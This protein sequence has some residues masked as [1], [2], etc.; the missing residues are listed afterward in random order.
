MKN[1]RIGIIGNA[2]D[3][4]VELLKRRVEDLGARATVIDFSQFPHVTKASIEGETVTYDD[5]ELTSLDAFYLRQMGYFSPIPQKE[6]TKEEWADYYGKFNDYLAGQRE[7]LSFTESVIQILSELRPVINPYQVAFYHRLKAYQYWTLAAGGLAV[8]EFMA[9]NDFFGMHE[10]LGRVPSV[11][12]PL[13]GGFVSRYS[14]QDL[15]RDKDSLRKRPILLQREITGRMLRSFVLGGRLVGTCE[16]ISKE[17][18]ADSRREIL[19]MK[20]FSLTPAHQAI[21]IKACKVLGMI[22][23][24]VDLLLDEKSDTLHVLE[25]N[26]AP[27]FRNFEVQTGLPISQELARYLVEEAAK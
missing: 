20:I 8:P 23:A 14:P 16:I 24:G 18:E 11:V 3:P 5:L 26:P 9:G 17:G 6:L 15:A 25:A 19:A 7:T 21:P 1:H 27:F 4:E 2:D 10:F 22:F 12:K 13:T